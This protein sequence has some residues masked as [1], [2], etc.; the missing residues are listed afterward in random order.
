[1]KD[2]A[3][4][5][6]KYAPGTFP[7]AT[8][9]A[10]NYLKAD[11]AGQNINGRNVD[12]EPTGPNSTLATDKHGNQLFPGPGGNGFITR[13]PSCEQDT[14]LVNADKSNCVHGAKNTG[15]SWGIRRRQ[16]KSLR[17]RRQLD[18]PS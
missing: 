6:Q 7:G 13:P 3:P 12:W 15:A 2:L 16:P 5:Y 9:T 10:R 17:H 18:G 1:M 11:L 4:G 8:T 14:K